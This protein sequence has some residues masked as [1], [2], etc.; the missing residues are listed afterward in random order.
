[1]IKD[2]SQTIYWN[3]RFD[4][5]MDLYNTIDTMKCHVPVGLEQAA[6]TEDIKVVTVDNYPNPFNPSTTLSFAIPSQKTDERYALHIYNIKGQL[7]RTL[8]KGVV[9]NRGLIRKVL[10]DGTDNLGIAVGGGIYF[11]RLDVGTKVRKGCM[12]FVK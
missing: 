9:G 7:V 1:M 4:V 10:W 5:P 12:V 6:A 2:T 11:Y 8:E 3:F